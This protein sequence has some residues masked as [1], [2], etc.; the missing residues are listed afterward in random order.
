METTQTTSKLYFQMHSIIYSFLILGIVLLGL[1]VSVFIADFQHID[2]QSDLAKLLE[3]LLPLLTA[4]GIITCKMVCTFKLNS[5]K[6]QSDLKLKLTEYGSTMIIRCA[7]LEVPAL[8]AIVAVFVTSNPD[9]FIYCGVMILIMI[10]RRPTLKLAVSDLDLG[11]QE[12]SI[13][14]DP[15]SIID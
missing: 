4:V 15:D 12:I 10:A 13:L 8:V 11:P 14:K 9:Y 6:K 3:Y 7:L 5:I 1:I 2:R